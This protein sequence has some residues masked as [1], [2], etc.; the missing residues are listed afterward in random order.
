MTTSNYISAIHDYSTNSIKVWER[1]SDGKRVVRSYDA[2]YYFYVEDKNGS[3][4]SLKGKKL[5]RLDFRTRDDFKHALDFHKVKYESDISP[6]E[7]ILMNMYYNLPTP[8]LRVR[9]I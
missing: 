9:I 5:K 1:N 7:K 6:L 8:D 3:Y 4:T 2:P